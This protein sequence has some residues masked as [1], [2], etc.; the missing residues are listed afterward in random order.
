MS[1]IDESFSVMNYKKSHVQRL[2]VVYND[3]IRPP[4]GW[5]VSEI[6]R[7]V[8]LQEPRRTNKSYLVVYIYGPFQK[9]TYLGTGWHQVKLGQFFNQDCETIYIWA[10][11][12]L[13]IF[14]CMYTVYC[15]IITI[16]FFQCFFICLIKSKYL[17]CNVWSYYYQCHSS[18]SSTKLEIV[19]CF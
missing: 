13:I 4:R 6:F 12:W 7:I 19:F 11:S 5:S 15:Y 17:I 3:G 2:N 10:V 14:S 9:I 18:L 8:G 1:F 16:M